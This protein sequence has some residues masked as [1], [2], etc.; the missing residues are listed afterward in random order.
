MQVLTDIFHAINNVLWGS[1]M[2]IVL[3]GTGCYLTI[4]LR[5][6]QVFKMPAMIKQVVGPLFKKNE[7]QPSGMT[8]FQALATSIAAQVGTGNLA[9]V[10]TAIASG[11]PGSIVWMWISSFLGMATIFSEAVLAQLFKVKSGNQAYGGPAF[12]ISMG[13]N[14]RWLAG[15]FAVAVV[16]ALGLIGN[17]VQSNS[18]AAAFSTAFPIRSSTIGILL[19]VFVGLIIFG[20]VNRIASVAEKVIPFMAL[21][22]IIGCIVILVMHVDALLPGIR[23]MINDAFSSEAAGGGL[24]GATVKE[25]IRYGISRGLF[26][27]EAGMGSTPHAHAAAD[28]NHPVEQGF[29]AM[30]GVL[31]DTLLICTLTALVIISTGAFTTDE[32]SIALT[33]EGFMRGFG[34]FGQYFIAIS[35]LFFSFTTILGWYYYGET[36][37]RFLFGNRTVLY[38]CLVL[39]FVFIGTQLKIGLVW[40]IADTLNAFMILPNVMALLALSGLVAKTLKSYR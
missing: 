31:I 28:V 19:V 21:F 22:Y 40:E 27:N 8:S 20:G 39:G 10:A 18:I 9:G 36:N 5:F 26:T 6:L 29:V 30:L 4:R 33:Q 12:Y 37:V 7:R 1:V 38:R 24:L 25:A 32:T 2:V 16:L 17:M 3:L 11:G 23:L 14:Q 15:F 34:A 35:L 13:L